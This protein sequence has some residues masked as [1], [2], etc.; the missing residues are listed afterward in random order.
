MQSAI[1]NI[2]L[3]LVAIAFGASGKFTL[4]GTESA[5]ALIIFG[6]ALSAFGVVQAVRHLSG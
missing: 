4:V 2:V 1:F 6:V 5:T 3:G